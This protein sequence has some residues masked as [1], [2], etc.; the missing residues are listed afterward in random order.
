M[1]YDVIIAG[2]GGQGVL[3]VS[4]IIA[5]AALNDGL[6]VRQSEVHGMAQRGGAVLSH[7]RICDKQIACDLVPKGGADLIISMEPLEGLRYISYLKPSGSLV[8]NTDPVKNMDN[9]P[10]TA[11]I[12]STIKSLPAW[13]LI[14]AGNLAKE[15]G[16]LK[17]VNI[18][19]VGAVSCFL[20][21]N[22]KTLEK[23]IAEI[24]SKKDENVVSANAK[25]FK[26]G[27]NASK[28][29]AGKK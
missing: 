11:K 29:D 20:P 21:L 5:Q 13:R 8:T 16:N 15:A 25:A 23:T 6:E 9:Y 7:L 28:H 22:A 4:S 26:L 24:F 1:K 18:V 17:A 10:D 2:V 12:I 27:Q 19:M 14:D 3:S